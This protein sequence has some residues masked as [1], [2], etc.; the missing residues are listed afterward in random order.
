MI[1][2]LI[3]AITAAVVFMHL[4]GSSGNLKQMTPL[5]V[6][7][8]FLLSAILSAFIL[9]KGVDILEFIIIVLIYGALISILDR[10]AFSTNFGRRIFVGSP[11]VIIQNGQLDTEKMEKLKI[12]ARDL[13]VAMRQNKIHSLNE[14]E[15]A[16][17]EP[18]GDFTIVK[19]GAKQYSFVLIDNGMIDKSALQKIHRN[20]K[21]LRHE[22][23]MK[24]IRDINDIFIAQWYNRKLYIVKKNQGPD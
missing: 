23:R 13:A 19:K 5:S 1:L 12:S 22:L 8:N 17:I 3:I 2:K 24:K 11:Q 7:I 18:S 6:I 21:W 9:N 10:L 15:M 20:E 4:F 14:I 16:Q